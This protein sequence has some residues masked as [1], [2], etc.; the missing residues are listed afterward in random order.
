M[1]ELDVRRSTLEAETRDA[2][3]TVW[4][5][6]AGGDRAQS[7]ARRTC[8]NSL[9]TN[10]GKRSSK[11]RSITTSP[12]R[13]VSGSLTALADQNRLADQLSQDSIQF[14]ILKR[15][16]ESDRQLHEGLLQRLKET[17]VSSGLKSANV[18][19][20]DR[21]QVPRR[22]DSPNVPRN[23]ALG[24][25][26]GLISGIMCAF[27]VAFLDRTVKTPEDV[28]REL[29]LPFLGAIPTFDKS[30]RAATGGILVPPRVQPAHR[31][32][33]LTSVRPST[34][35]GK[36]IAPSERRCSFVPPRAGRKTILVTSALAGEGK[37]TTAV[38]LAIVL[39]QT[40]A[41]TLLVE[42]DMRRPALADMFQVPRTHGMSR[43]LS[44]QCEL[45]TE[46]QR[47][48]IP[49][50]MFVAGWPGASQPA[51]IDWSARLNAGAFNCWAGTSITSS[52]TVRR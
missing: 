13:T 15:E 27:A 24:L 46:I 17:D 34:C 2:D 36:P 9:I 37:S 25:T 26:L 51:R 1:K 35:I 45:N 4:V 18:H 28:E 7:R 21:G 48:G 16:V 14:N 52:S 8:N 38:N 31:E 10:E 50:L 3:T 12:S 23:L 29:R 30:W 11:P 43:Y 41:R 32:L 20:I 47:T 42:L 44:G 5:E 19:V 6:V 33:H 49:N 39:A 40:G 22:P